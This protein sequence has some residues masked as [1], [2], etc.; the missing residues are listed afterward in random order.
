MFA[1]TNS[2]QKIG[3]NC[4]FVVNKHEQK[5]DI[6]IMLE[7]TEKIEIRFVCNL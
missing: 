2:E 5:G 1:V 6:V 7:G 4:L 3:Q